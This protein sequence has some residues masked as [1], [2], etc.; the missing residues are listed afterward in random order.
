ML[1]IKYNY[2]VDNISLPKEMA[3]V[4]ARLCPLL[5]FESIEEL[6]NTLDREIFNGEKLQHED[7]VDIYIGLYTP[8]VQR[9]AVRSVISH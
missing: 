4:A 1:K 2:G 5:S 6:V 8:I 9:K 7:A 3:D